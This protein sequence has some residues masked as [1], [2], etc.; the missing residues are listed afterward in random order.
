[1]TRLP[2][3]SSLERTRTAMS[4]PWE[5]EPLLLEADLVIG[6]VL[7]P[8]ARAPHLVSEELVARMR[9]GS[10]LV[11]VAID[12]GG[13]SEVSRP[14]THESPT[15]RV[16]GTTVYAV[17]NM[18]GAVPVTSTRALTNATLP[19]LHELAN[20]GDTIVEGRD[21]AHG[22]HP[23]R[24]ALL[25]GLRAGLTTHGGEVRNEVVARAHRL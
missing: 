1:M 20:V 5:I 2:S 17:T 24:A 13:C 14:T 21:P 22:L 23:R 9:P 3:S 7:V 12:Q 18:P 8:G 4:N 25:A 11:D 6:A 16:H 10:V 19:Y 15:Y